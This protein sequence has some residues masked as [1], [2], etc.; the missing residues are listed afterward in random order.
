MT[1][2]KINLVALLQEAVMQLVEKTSQGTN[3][4][5]DRDGN[6]GLYFDFQHALTFC[7]DELKILTMNVS[8]QGL[9][10][11]VT[12]GPAITSWEEVRGA[13]YRLLGLVAEQLLVVT[14]SQD[15]ATFQFWFATG[16]LTL[17][18]PHGHLG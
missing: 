4:G 1:S 12:I 11:H 2:S 8:D 10:V 14:P 16:D 15:E 6:L 3:W 7:Q 5:Q 17:L 9:E 13:V 18:A